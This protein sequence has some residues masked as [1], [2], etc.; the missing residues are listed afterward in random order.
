VSS[1]NK[2]FVISAP[3]GSG[4]T[5]IM[6]S[7]MNN[8]LISF[9]TREPRKNEINGVDYIFITK[10][11]FT[12][13]LNNNGLMEHTEYYGSN[14][15]G[16]TQQEFDSKIKIG[17]CFFIADYTGLKQMKEKYDNI[18]SIFIYCEREECEKNMRLRGDSEEN[19]LKRLTTYDIEIAN[20]YKY[21]HI[22]TNKFGY[23]NDTIVK[24]KD[25]IGGF[26]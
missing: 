14:F 21:D 18:I 19:I 23:L 4:K 7:I 20:A 6:R 13:L 5:T 24:V 1:M 3:S 22:V 2:L 26:E 9:T 15:Y 16:L 10:E 11:K 12:Y 17:D 25:I 8:E